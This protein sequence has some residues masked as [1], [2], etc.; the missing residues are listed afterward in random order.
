MKF[1]VDAMFGRLARWLRLSGFDTVYDVQ[2]RNGRIVM[3]A[4]EQERAVITRDKDVHCRCL[5]AGI[6]ATYI[7]SLNFPEQLKQVIDEYGVSF[8]DAP[9]SSRCPI[10]NSKLKE[11]SKKDIKAE[12]P[13]KVRDTYDEFWKCLGCG[14]V[15]WHGGHWKNIKETVDRLKGAKDD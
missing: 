6:R 11:A 12:L 8:Q 5:S 3:M 10:C 7:T 13:E 9:V 14:K 2:L 15:Y 4:L 1:L